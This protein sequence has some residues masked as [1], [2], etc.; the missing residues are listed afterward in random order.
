[1]VRVNEYYPLGQTSLKGFSQ[2]DDLKQRV[3]R[4]QGTF[5]IIYKGY[6]LI[7]NP[8]PSS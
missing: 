7:Y 2:Y 6:V 3:S 8:N 4:V 1:M 5:T